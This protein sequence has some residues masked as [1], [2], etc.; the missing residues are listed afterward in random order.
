[1]NFLY[2]PYIFYYKRRDDNMTA[3]QHNFRTS[4]LPSQTQYLIRY[5]QNL[6]SISFIVSPSTAAL[7][8]KK[9]ASA[10]TSRDSCCA[11]GHVTTETMYL[12]RKRLSY[13]H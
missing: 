2:Q 1:M 7:S 10:G 11:Q 8:H 4:P 6:Q 5:L 9:P 12:P 13:C 3:E